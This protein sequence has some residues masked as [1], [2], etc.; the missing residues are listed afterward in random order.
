M[1]LENLIYSNMQNYFYTIY[2]LIGFKKYW[3]DLFIG[4]KIQKK[5]HNIN[6]KFKYDIKPY[7]IYFPQFH[8]IYENDI[9]FYRGFNDIK[10]LQ[11]FNKNEVIQ[12]EIPL[13][14]YCN[15][16]IYNYITNSTLLQK[17]IDLI[18]EY[19][20][21]GLAIYYYWFT[22]NSITDKNMIMS[23]VINKFFDTKLK[24]Y[25]HK[26]FFIWANEDCNNNIALSDNK[27]TNIK[28]IYDESSFIKNA[29]NLIEYFKNE[30]YLKID[31]KPVFFIYHNYLIDNIGEFHKILHDKCVENN[32]DGVNLVLNSFEKENNS[33]KN[34]YI[35]F[36]Y[37]KYTSRFFDDKSKQ[38]KIDYKK[39]IDDPYHIKKGKI[40]TIVYDFDNRPRLY[41]PPKLNASSICV[42]NT[43]M[44]K[45]VFTRKLVETYNNN[46]YGE[47]DK[48]L[49]VNALNEWGENMVFE[50]SD[51]YGYYNINLLKQALI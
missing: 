33:F 8:D 25:N 2:P 14:E 43:E 22:E 19:G 50:P 48:I 3:N 18:S 37:K 28:N 29:D 27:L 51:K 13:Q 21:Y 10:N 26:I 38:I 5:V 45:I 41:K 30:R 40:Q 7:F 16:S 20:F 23:D 12:K 42:N 46:D 1:K 17:Q 36:N 44:H 11:I 49:L 4:N 39:Y 31:N 35:N 24:L 6:F 32:F 47:L 15:I 34:F 9:N